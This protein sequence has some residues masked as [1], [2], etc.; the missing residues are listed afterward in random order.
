MENYFRNTLIPQLFVDAKLILRKFTPPAMKQFNLS[1]GDIG[2][3]IFEI[4]DNIR[5]PSMIENIQA[6]AETK[7]ILEEEIQTT[8]FRWYRMNIIPYIQEED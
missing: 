8:D 3:S 4:E 2:K 7:E 6:V 1:P 5:Y